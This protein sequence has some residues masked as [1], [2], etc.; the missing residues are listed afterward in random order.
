MPLHPQAQAL[1]DMV[2]AMGGA[3]A[4]DERLQEARDGLALLTAG[5]AGDPQPVAHVD[6][7]VI[8]GPP[9]DIPVRVYRPN[10]T[11]ALPVLVWLHGGGWTIGSVDVHDP[12]TRALAN[13]AEC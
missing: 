5:G 1:C 3:P 7:R 11:D 4:S 9:G 2:N 6:D 10:D 12:I 13:A 8:P